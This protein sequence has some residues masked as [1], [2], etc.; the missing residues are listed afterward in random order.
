MSLPIWGDSVLSVFC[1]WQS[2]FPS[3]Y[4]VPGGVKSNLKTCKDNT[5][6][7]KG[8]SEK[9]FRQRASEGEI[10]LDPPSRAFLT[11][12]IFKGWL[13]CW[14]IPAKKVWEG[15][16]QSVLLYQLV[17][18]DIFPKRWPIVTTHS[19]PMTW[20]GL[21]N[22]LHTFGHRTVVWLLSL[23]SSE[24]LGPLNLCCLS[25]NATLQ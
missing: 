14:E 19:S 13:W 20:P 11:P 24:S 22:L 12:D 6:S 25:P 9:G 23:R 7:W 3:W 21:S 10:W 1:N 5:C 16:V 17:R 18:E 8:S 4:F 15:K 2:L